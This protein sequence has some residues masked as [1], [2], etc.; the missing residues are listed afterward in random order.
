MCNAIIAISTATLWQG[1]VTFQNNVVHVW[2]A[3]RTTS[4][5][6]KSKKLAK[7]MKT[8]LV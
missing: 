1:D 3:K 5:E 7:N 2:K 4:V 8:I 6:L